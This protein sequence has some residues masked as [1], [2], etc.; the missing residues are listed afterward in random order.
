MEQATKRI[1]PLSGITWLA[2]SGRPDAATVASLKAAGWRW[3]GYR[4]EWY[5]NR[6]APTIPAGVEVADGGTCDYA[7]ER[8]E[9][10]AV[11]AEKADARAMAANAPAHAIMDRIPLGQPIL[12]GHH[13]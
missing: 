13:S 5:S 7:A 1:D 8:S 11:A 10:L 2:F 3:S 6:R 12:V 9:R 4:Q